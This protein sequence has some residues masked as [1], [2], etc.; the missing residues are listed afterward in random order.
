MGPTASAQSITRRQSRLRPATLTVPQASF[1]RPGLDSPLA[2]WRP[3]AS[4]PHETHA[5]PRFPS[6]HP[7]SFL[8]L[9]VLPTPPHITE[10]GR[11][12]LVTLKAL[13]VVGLAA[14][15]CA[16]ATATNGDDIHHA[17]QFTPLVT[18]ESRRTLALTESG[19][20]TAVDV[21]DGYRNAHHLQFITMEP[22][23]VFLPVLLHA[24]M[25]LYVHT[26]RGTVTFIGEG[27]EEEIDVVR[28]DV[29]RLEQGTTFYV[30]SHPDPA[31]ERLR[32]HA[33]FG[34]EEVDRYSPLG[35]SAGVYSNISDLVLGFDD[36]ILQMAFGVSAETIRGIKSAPATS[37]IVPF[38]PSNKMEEPNWKEEII[39]TLFGVRGTSDLVNKK[40]NKKKKKSESKAFNFFK[41]KPDV[42]NANGWSIALTHK[43]LKALKGSHLAPFMVNLTRGSM[44]GPHWNPRASEIAIVIRGKGMVQLVCPSDASGKKIKGAAAAAAKCQRAK[45]KVEEGSV[46]VVPRFHPMS[47]ISF[48]D[49]TLAFVGFSS[50]TKNNHPQFLAGKRSVLQVIDADVLAAAFNVNSSVAEGLLA[51]QGEAV[52]L[53]CTSC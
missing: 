26:G 7:P 24:D 15:L 50:A 4:P 27:S 48:N 6:S 23:S 21:H 40:K 34:T 18:K 37:P 42:K 12:M 39:E 14:L 44:M 32:I 33:I 43:D 10:N 46:F 25:V 53:P 3:C 13:V 29:Y 36:N 35:L 17:Q 49:E 38:S 11:D 20:I 52:V 19:M 5:C 28:G 9:Y 51:A 1:T 8:C 16:L 22:G 2:T 45:F 41:A 30:K 47:Q 31:R